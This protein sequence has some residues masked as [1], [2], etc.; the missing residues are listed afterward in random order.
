[1]G[2]VRTKTVKRAARELIEKYYGKITDDFHL[3]K[4]L[5]NKVSDVSSKRLRNKIAGYS[6]HLIKRIR[7]KPVKGISLKMQ[8][9][10]NERRMDTI[11][12]DTRIKADATNFE[13]TEATLRML[14]DAG[15]AGL[16]KNKNV[17]GKSRFNA[18]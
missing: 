11:E 10:Q 5:L 2:R 15:V 3:N 17:V 1:M 9:E 16:L 7:V 18:N 12:G 13:V 6:V 4:K 8:E 14:K